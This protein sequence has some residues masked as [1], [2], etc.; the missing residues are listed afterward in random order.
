MHKAPWISPVNRK[1]EGS[2]EEVSIYGVLY[3]VIL[4][5]RVLKGCLEGV[6]A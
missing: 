2:D 3:M 6:T 5:R 4:C 1:P